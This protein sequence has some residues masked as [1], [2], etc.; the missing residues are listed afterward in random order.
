MP[1]NIILIPVNLPEGRGGSGT[2]VKRDERRR[3]EETWGGEEA[4]VSRDW[5]RVGPIPETEFREVE[6]EVEGEEKDS[7]KR[8]RVV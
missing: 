1:E 7:R 2:T 3:R 8:G 5:I 6:K 4:K